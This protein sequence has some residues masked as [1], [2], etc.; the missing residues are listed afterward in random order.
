MAGYPYSNTTLRVDGLT[1]QTPERKRRFLTAY[2]WQFPENFMSVSLIEVFV[3]FLAPAVNSLGH[4]E[5]RANDVLF[6]VAIPPKADLSLLSWVCSSRLG[7]K[8]KRSYYFA[9]LL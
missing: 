1:N 2:S 9:A 6:V 8:T 7:S 3:P 4:R 5:K